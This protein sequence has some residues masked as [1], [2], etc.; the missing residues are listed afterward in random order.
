MIEA[1][2][3]LRAGTIRIG[4]RD[5]EVVDVGSVPR[6]R[7]VEAVSQCHQADQ[8]RL[9]S[10]EVCEGAINSFNRYCSELRGRLDALAHQSIIDQR[11]Q[12][13]VVDV[14]MRKALQW[15]RP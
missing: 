4:G 15:R 9:P 1:D 5:G 13:A 6:A 2:G 8:I 3:I 7:F 10:D 11:R 14:L 12:R